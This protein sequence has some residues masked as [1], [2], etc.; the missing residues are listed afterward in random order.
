M[1]QRAIHLQF[2][3]YFYYSNFTNTLC[4]EGVESSVPFYTVTHFRK[5]FQSHV[6]NRGVFAPHLGTAAPLNDG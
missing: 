6:V 1:F 3:L 2:S 4:D 5:P